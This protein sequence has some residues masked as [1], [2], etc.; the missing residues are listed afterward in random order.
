MG[1]GPGLLQ[2]VAADVDRV[3]L[4]DVA[5][6]VGDGVDGQAPA[7]QRREDER[8]PGQVLLDDVVLGGAGQDPRVDALVLGVG[9]VEAE[10]PRRGGVDGHRRVHRLDRDLVEQLGHV[11]EVGDRHADLADLAGGRRVVGVVADLGREV[12]GD[13]E[14]GLALGQVGPVELVGGLGRRVA[15][16]G[17]HHPRL[18]PDRRPRA[19][20]PCRFL[21]C[22]R[23]CMSSLWPER[24][25]RTGAAAGRSATSCSRGSPCRTSG[26]A[27]RR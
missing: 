21:P 23:R 5:H 24:A 22:R 4:R 20:R 15:R 16:V 18:V 9:D 8:A 10:Q 7:G 12:E 2:V 6:R 25:R 26:P 27:A 13:G 14:A 11:A 17:A 1:G 19:D 3:P